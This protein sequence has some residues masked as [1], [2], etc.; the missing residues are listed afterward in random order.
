MAL[1][2]KSKNKFKQTEIGK[3][4]KD[5]EIVKL[6]DVAVVNNLTLDN[7]FSYREIEYIDIAAVNQGFISEIKTIPLKEAPS[8]AKRI[9]RN[10]DIVLSTVRPNLKHFAFMKNVKPNTV[11]STGFAVITSKNIHPQFLYYYI[12]TDRYTYYLSAIADMHTSAYPACNPDVIENSLIPYPLLP[13]QRAIA[14]ILSD[15]DEKIELNRQM[16]KTLESIAQA[17]FKHWLVDFEFPN[18]QGKP[19]KSSGGKMENSELGEIPMCWRIGAI[20]DIVNIQSGFAFKSSCFNDE[21]QYGLVTIKNVQDGCFVTKCDN[22]LSETPSEMPEYCFL[23]N[24]DIILSLTGNV[25]RVCLVHGKNYLLNQRVAKLEPRLG[26]DKAFV[27]CLFRQ[28]SFKRTLQNIARGTA[29]SNLSPVE[30]SDLSVLVPKSIIFG[31]FEGI[32]GAIVDMVVANNNTTQRLV[33]IRDSLLPKL[34][35]GKI[36]LVDSERQSLEE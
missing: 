7:S 29:Q 16:N 32:C 11:A 14:K 24:G 15:L 25:G 20:K 5:W 33:Q 22:S 26:D 12:S 6:S 36:R 9:V 27:Y 13:D 4:P 3:I 8:R 35:S 21:G 19:Y 18:E 31:L 2:Y 17:I 1:K 10:N 34:L 28:P 23:Q 30:T